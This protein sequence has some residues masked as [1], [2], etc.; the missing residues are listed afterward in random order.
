M[1]RYEDLL[2]EEPLA[3]RKRGWRSFIWRHLLA[4]TTSLLV[5][6]LMIVVLWPFVVITVPSGRVGVYWKRFPVF[7]FYCWCIS[8]GTVLDPREL[9]N[10]GLHFIWP[11]DKLFIYDLRLQSSSQ[12]INAISKDG[13]SVTAQ[14]NVRYQLAHRAVAVLHK[15]IGPQY[16]ETVIDP[17]V[18]SVAREVISKY[19]AEEVYTSRDPIQSQVRAGTQKSL[20]ANL[21]RLVQPEATEQP[22]PKGYNDFLQGSI[23]ILDILV[24]SIELPA[25]IVNAINRQTEQFYL[26]QEYRFKVES[27]AEESK[28]KQIEA[29]GIAAFQQTVSKGISDSYLRWKGIDATLR[30]AQSPNTKIVVIGSGGDGLPIIFNAD[31]RAPAAQPSAATRPAATLPPTN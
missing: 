15:F 11:W 17:E 30:L 9:K 5:A 6:L 16:V 1:A 13:V 21:D 12:T 3:P 25:A 24:L 14:M 26:I 23:V 19:T 31:T 27:E 7:D 18:G 2:N 8:R 4:V 20:G 22:D 28:R 10:E 29:N